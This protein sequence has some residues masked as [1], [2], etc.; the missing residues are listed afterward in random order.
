MNIIS[1]ITALRNLN[2]RLGMGKAIATKIK[3]SGRV[4]N[5]TAVSMRFVSQDDQ[6]RP[7][8]ALEPRLRFSFIIIRRYGDDGKEGIVL[9]FQPSRTSTQAAAI[10][11]DVRSFCIS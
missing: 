2:L 7:L 11:A 10:R 4:R 8:R 3:V 5:Y 9:T 6:D 1:K